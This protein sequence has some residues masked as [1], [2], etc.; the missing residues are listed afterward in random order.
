MEY[1]CCHTASTKV[2]RSYNAIPLKVVKQTQRI[3][4]N[5]QL[6][7]LESI[8]TMNQTHMVA[9]ATPQMLSSFLTT[10]SNALESKQE[11]IVAQYGH[12]V[13]LDL[14]I[15]QTHIHPDHWA[16]TTNEHHKHKQTILMV[17]R[18]KD[19]VHGHITSTT[20]CTH[21]I[22]FCEVHTI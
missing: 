1:Q 17:V 4:Y 20:A 5:A 21:Q 7:M 14:T 8:V 6:P 16:Q 2:I 13:V 9:V 18:R 11:M 10:K 19:N 15:S 3:Q 12:H 22:L